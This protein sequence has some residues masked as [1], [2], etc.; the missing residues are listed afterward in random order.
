MQQEHPDLVIT[1]LYFLRALILKME[2]KG[3]LVT[4]HLI[5]GLRLRLEECSR[6]PLNKLS[7]V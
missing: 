4:R 6:N 1:V 5:V 7:A 2:D 3:H